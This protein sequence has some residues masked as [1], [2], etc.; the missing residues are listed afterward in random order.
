M[1]ASIL[2]SAGCIGLAGLVAIGAAVGTG[3]L[4]AQPVARP[5]L[6]DVGA[7]VS[8]SSPPST[9]SALPATRT[10]P[11]ASP[12]PASTALD[13]STT[14]TPS[15]SPRRPR[16]SARPTAPRVASTTPTAKRTP[17]RTPTSTPQK[18]PAA[19]RK[20][21]APAKAPQRAPSGPTSWPALNAAIYRIPGYVPDGIRWTVTSRYGHWGATDLATGD[22][23]ISPS[24]STSLLDSVV[25]HEYAHVVTVRAYG[26]AWRTA[27]SEMNVAFGGS[28][29]TGVERAADCM[30]RAMG[31]SWTNYTTCGREDWQRYARQLL[32]GRPL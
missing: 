16:P 30:A 24:V 5:A 29:R 1:R 27:R 11:P 22:I 7:V 3:A 18:K 2:L 14:G 19:P 17:A 4:S 21:A 10:A 9:S 25:R 28:G 13:P 12:R 31:A 15:A 32:A 20:T 6:S 26:G 8:A 23:Y